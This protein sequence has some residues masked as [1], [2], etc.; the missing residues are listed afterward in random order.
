M[1]PRSPLLSVDV[2][3]RTGGGIVLIRRR[4]GDVFGGMWALPGGGVEYGERVEDAALR[5]AKEE[6]GLEIELKRLLGVYS[7][8]GRDPRGHVVTIVFL[9]EKKG[10]TLRAGSDAADV[11]VVNEINEPL[12]F[13]HL[14][15]LRDSGVI[16]V[17]V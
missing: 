17:N 12:A 13:D 11:R 4:E 6:T 9:A 3:I 2:V 16:R 10:G 15:I 1:T 8:P 5:E 14:Q 7:D